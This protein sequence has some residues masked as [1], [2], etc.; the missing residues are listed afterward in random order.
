VS[1]VTIEQLTSSFLPQVL[2][3]RLYEWGPAA[4][5]W[6]LGVTL[7]FMMT[8]RL[9]F[10]VP[11]ANKT[12]GTGS[13]RLADP[14]FKF[15]PDLALSPMGRDLVCRLLER[16]PKVRLGGGPTGEPEIRFTWWHGERQHLCL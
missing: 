9:P 2:L 5:A 12:V 4:D 15:P 8:G 11:D 13:P 1:L 7:Y 10:A 6:A 16:N 3:Q 14:R